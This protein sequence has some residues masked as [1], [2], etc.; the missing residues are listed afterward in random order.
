MTPVKS[1]CFRANLPLYAPQV[2]VRFLYHN[3]YLLPPMIQIELSAASAASAD[4]C[5]VR[6]TPAPQPTLTAE[7][8]CRGHDRPMAFR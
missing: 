2:P 6:L 7:A 8:L 1:S 5:R 3:L 4:S